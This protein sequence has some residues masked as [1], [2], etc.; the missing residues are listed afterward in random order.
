MTQN[1]AE[2]QEMRQLL[3][4]RLFPRISKKCT[5]TLRLDQNHLL[6]SFERS[7]NPAYYTLSLTTQQDEE[8][9]CLKYVTRCCIVRTFEELYGVLWEIR[10][11][12]WSRYATTP[13]EPTSKRRHALFQH[14]RIVE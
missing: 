4:H 1:R 13:P 3:A 12:R 10:N 8:T 2:L 9:A 11:L 7:T 5:R 6:H 14:V